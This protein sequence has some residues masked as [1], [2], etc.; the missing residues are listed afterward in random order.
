MLAAAGRLG[1]ETIGLSTISNVDSVCPVRASEVQPS[2]F[3]VKFRWY[4]TALDSFFVK[5]CHYTS[6]SCV[7]LYPNPALRCSS[8]AES[9]F[10]Q[11][12]KRPRNFD[13]FPCRLESIYRFSERLNFLQFSTNLLRSAGTGC[14]LWLNSISSLFPK[15]PLQGPHLSR[16]G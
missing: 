9:L 10:G 11:I 14:V 13:S 1:C 2:G 15:G 16:Q 5:H 12:C 8:G 7:H 3:V 4:S 6:S